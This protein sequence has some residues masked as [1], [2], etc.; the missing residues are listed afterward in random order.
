[1]WPLWSSVFSSSRFLAPWGQTLL[2]PVRKQF[3]WNA[4]LN[5]LLWPERESGSRLLPE[6]AAVREGKTRRL[7]RHPAGLGGLQLR[8][9]DSGTPY[10]PA[11][12]RAAGRD[13]RF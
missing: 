9:N 3:S 13:N 4:I 6:L 2:S 12:N 10:S 11:C 7:N 8:F 1:M 5:K